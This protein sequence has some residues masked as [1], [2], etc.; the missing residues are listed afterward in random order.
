MDNTR[1]AVVKSRKID[2]NTD[3]ITKL[4]SHIKDCENKI[5][6]IDADHAKT[7]EALAKA[8]QMRKDE[9]NAWKTTDADDKAAA[10]TVM[11]AKNVLAGFYKDNDLN[12]MQ[13]Q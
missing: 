4:A 9:N 8:T 10:E 6:E 1:N 5:A 13:K 2:E 11:N 12:L 3:L 7:K